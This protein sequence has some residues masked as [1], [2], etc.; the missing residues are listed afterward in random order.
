MAAYCQMPLKGQAMHFSRSGLPAPNI[1]ISGLSSGQVPG[2]IY[3]SARQDQGI[4]QTGGA[5]PNTML[6]FALGASKRGK[7]LLCVYRREQG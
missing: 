2:C 4:A 7:V 6:R 1:K 5:T 3:Q